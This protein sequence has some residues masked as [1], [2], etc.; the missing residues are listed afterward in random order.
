MFS[1]INNLLIRVKPPIAKLR[2]ISQLKANLSKKS[3]RHKKTIS[4]C[5]ANAHCFYNYTAEIQHLMLSVFSLIKRLN[6]KN[7]CLM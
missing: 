3:F 7:I 6:C 2:K 4:N 1:K 5:L